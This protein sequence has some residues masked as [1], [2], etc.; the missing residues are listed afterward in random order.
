MQHGQTGGMT[1][2]IIVFLPD[3][4]SV[5]HWLGGSGCLLAP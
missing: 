4:S 3:L 1:L 5:M 2:V